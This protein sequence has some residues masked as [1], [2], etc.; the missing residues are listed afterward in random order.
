MKRRAP[1]TLPDPEPDRPPLPPPISPHPSP[2]SSLARYDQPP[3]SRMF[4]CFTPGA[5]PPLRLSTVPSAG[6][7]SDLGAGGSTEEGEHVCVR[8]RTWP[9]THPMSRA[10]FTVS[11][12]V[13]ACMSC[14]RVP[15]GC[16]RF[17]VCVCAPVL[18]VCA[19][20][21]GVRLCVRV[22]EQGEAWRRLHEQQLSRSPSCGCDPHNPV[23]QYDGLEAKPASTRH[24]SAS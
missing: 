24:R 5:P 15:N 11:E 6:L 21:T 18:R 9:R 10:S 13:H 4:P 22:W 8:V 7:R 19:A 14:A 2:P 23:N 1:P 3:S 16:Q 20:C 17:S 12:C